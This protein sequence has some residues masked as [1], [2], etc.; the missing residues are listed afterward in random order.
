M[1]LFG[2]C[3]FTIRPSGAAGIQ[4]FSLEFWTREPCLERQCKLW[5]F[6]KDENGKEYEGCVFEFASLNIS[7]I[8]ENYE[9]KKK[10][11]QDSI[12]VRKQGTTL[13]PKC[14]RT[15]DS[16]WKVCLQCNTPLIKN[17]DAK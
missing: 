9:V 16:S 15:Y 4:G 17:P 13:C 14:K 1:T 7:T 10:H 6:K 12:G 5:T 11:I 3:P 2:M 8:K